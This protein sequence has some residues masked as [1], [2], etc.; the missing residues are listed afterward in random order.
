M[1]NFEMFQLNSFQII[2][3]AKHSDIEMEI[4]SDIFYVPS[5]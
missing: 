1:A 5:S 4:I 3:Y 2:P